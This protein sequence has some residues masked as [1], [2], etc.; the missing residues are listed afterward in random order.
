[1]LLSIV[2]GFVAAVAVMALVLVSET[3]PRLARLEAAERERSRGL[4]ID[5]ECFAIADPGVLRRVV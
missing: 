1:M 5:A 3:L 2:L 4:I